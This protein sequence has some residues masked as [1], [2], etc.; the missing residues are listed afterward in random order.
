MKKHHHSQLLWLKRAAVKGS[1]LTIDARRW[2]YI[3]TALG[4]LTF[5]W[6]LVILTLTFSST[7]F[8]SKWT[9]I[10]PG[11]GTGT[12]ISLENLG[13]ATSTS[14]SPYTSTSID[15][16][17]NYKALSKS[18]M[19][20]NYAAQS[21]DISLGAM[22]E[23]KLKLPNQTGLIEFTISGKTA[24][25]AQDIAWAH[26][27][28]L[29]A[30]LSELRNDEALQREN[31]VKVSM[32]SFSK[33][34]SKS[35]EEILNFQ[36][37]IGLVS[38]EQFKEIAVIIERLRQNKVNMV[39]KLQ[40][41]I[42]SQK[43]L[44]THLS[45]NTKQASDL[46]KLK[47]DQ[48]YQQLLV[49]YTQTTTTLAEYSGRYGEKHP[50]VMT[51]T[52]Q[53]ENLFKALRKRCKELVGYQ[54]DSLMLKL[55][56]DD[57]DGRALLMKQLLSLEID[58]AGLSQE[59]NTLS[60]QIITWETRLKNSNNDAATL[61]DLHRQHQLATAV[62]TSAIA[63]MDIGKADIYSAYPLIQLLSPPTFPKNANNL[64]VILAILGGILSSLFCLAGLSI[65]W[66][67]KPILQKILM[68]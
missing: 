1:S 21:I 43:M 58:G 14:S 9:L 57:L 28:S 2:V 10:L 65:L 5:I 33:K 4:A 59:I 8:E 3:K 30:L 56:A 44:E 16:R 63:K 34:V 52:Q 55:S 47:N 26:Y 22:R 39:S 15:P 29:Q 23:P 6:T 35:Q 54:D 66:V 18:E 49:T 13:H 37:K 41:V 38:L 50:Q 24:Q 67:R 7:N 60:A 36:S 46:L 40:G 12:L 62:F 64:V 51:Q 31:G 25:E 53:Q 17:E 20:I 48:L 45:L 27:H 68:T 32:N 42:A 19:L 11:A 61:Q